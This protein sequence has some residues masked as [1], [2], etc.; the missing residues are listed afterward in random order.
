MSCSGCKE[1][2]PYT[3][4]LSVEK[5]RPVTEANGQVNLSKDSNWVHAWLT[6]ARFMTPNRPSFTTASGSEVQVGNQQIAVQ[7]VVIMVPYSSPS[8]IPLPS[9]RLR[10]GTRVF[11]IT[12]AFR[13]NECE[14]EIQIEA[15]EQRE[16]Q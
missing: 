11:N 2:P 10:L 8:R 9:Y 3:H 16:P 12:R 1:T 15:I 4:T 13:V 14:D 7:P 5:P 6:R